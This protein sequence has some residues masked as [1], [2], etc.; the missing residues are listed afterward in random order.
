MRVE[1]QTKTRVYAQKQLDIK[2]RPRITSLDE[3]HGEGGALLGVDAH[4]A[5]Q[6]EDVVGGV[7]HLLRV[8]HDLLELARFGET[9]DHLKKEGK[10]KCLLMLD[11]N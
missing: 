3:H 5:A 7:G 10:F 8:Q 9:L 11:Y 4:D 2:C 6:Q 1:N